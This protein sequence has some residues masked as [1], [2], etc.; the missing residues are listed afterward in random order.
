MKDKTISIIGAGFSGLAAASVLGA[1]GYDVNVY[2]KND[3]CGGRARVFHEKGFTFDMGPS[4]YWMPDVFEFFY[5]RFEKSA[6]DFYELKKLSPSY[7]IFF[8]K[9]DEMDIPDSM[10][11]MYELFEKVEAGSAAQLRKFL[12]EAEEKYR[13]AIHNR[14]VYFPSLSW[15]EYSSLLWKKETWKLQL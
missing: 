2:E 8:G 7:R 15:R 1:A 5:A 10:E 3:Q 12:K 6:A 13:I 9:N 4:W 14:L 11:V